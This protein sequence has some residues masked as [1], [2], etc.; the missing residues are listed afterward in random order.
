MKWYIAKKIVNRIKKNLRNYFYIILEVMIGVLLISIFYSVRLS[1]NDKYIQIKDNAE[2]TY[3]KMMVTPKLTDLNHQGNTERKHLENSVLATSA[4]NTIVPGF[5]MDDARWIYNKYGD[6]LSL[7]IVAYKRIF[8]KTN[9][10][11]AIIE[12]LAVSDDFYNLYI[13]NR[14]N[15]LFNKI[16]IGEGAKS[17]LKDCEFYND[18]NMGVSE[19]EIDFLR[20]IVLSDTIL[21]QDKKI[22]IVNSDAYI[23]ERIKYFI[24]DNNPWVKNFKPAYS[25]IMPIKYYSDIVSSSGTENVYFSIKFKNTLFSPSILFSII[26][27]LNDEY[28]GEYDYRIDTNLD[29]YKREVE[30]IKFI[31]DSFII[32]AG[33]SFIIIICGLS[34]ILLIIINKRSRELAIC[35]SMG[36]SKKMLFFEIIMESLAINAIGGISGMV[37]SLFILKYFVSFKDFNIIFDYKILTYITFVIVL[38][39]VLSAIPATIKIKRMTPI[40]ILKSL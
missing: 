21:Y 3:A 39:G 4:S 25:V 15:E 18:D 36:A 24:Q 12:E 32:L 8:V 40:Q 37:F 22:S 17:I 29:R 27:F 30:N 26:E 33:V 11:V 28:K 14:G 16:V 13:P 9:D 19:K 6:D 7:S 23:G 10:T 5:S 35:I 20:S 34:G 38:T 2:N 31:S 1:I